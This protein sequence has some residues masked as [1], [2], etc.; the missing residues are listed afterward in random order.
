MQSAHIKVGSNRLI[1]RGCAHSLV[2]QEAVVDCMAAV[3][4]QRAGEHSRESEARFRAAF[5]S[6]AVGMAL[7]SLEGQWLEVN[8]GLCAILGYSEEE[9]RAT[10][11]QALTHPDDAQLD[12]EYVARVVAGEMTSCQFEKRYFQKSGRIVWALL[13][14]SAITDATGRALYFVSQ[15][16]DI[17][18]ERKSRRHSVRASSVI[19]P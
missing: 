10:T 13:Y 11:Y 7:V 2:P 18:A 8:R 5:D 6:S 4:A 19:V 3:S 14:F 15:I 12:S 1:E 16:V 17:T 9:L